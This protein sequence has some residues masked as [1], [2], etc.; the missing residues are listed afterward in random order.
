MFGKYV[1]NET[2]NNSM[3]IEWRKLACVT[4]AIKYINSMLN[5]INT[6]MKNS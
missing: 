3:L 4:K 2:F 5:D 6:R 1:D